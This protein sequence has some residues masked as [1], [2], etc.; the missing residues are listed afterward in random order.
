MLP[1]PYLRVPHVRANLV[2]GAAGVF[3]D[4]NGSSRGISNRT[5]LVRLLDLRKLAD[6]VV[7]DGETARKEGYRVPKTSD[8]AVITAAGYSPKSTDSNHKYIELR[9]NP[10]AAIQRLLDEGYTRILLELGPNLVAAL[11]DDG[12]IDEL[13]LTNSQGSTPDLHKLGI[14]SAELVFDEVAEDTRFSIWNQIR[15]L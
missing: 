6:V 14:Y 11:V 10:G 9:L 8:L 15:S 7:T 12:M 13:C 3:V 5:D 1:E 2:Q 4:S